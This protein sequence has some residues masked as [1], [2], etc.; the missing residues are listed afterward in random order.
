MESN[1]HLALN[2]STPAVLRDGTEG[3]RDYRANFISGAKG[4]G[5]RWDSRAIKAESLAVIAL[6][7][8]VRTG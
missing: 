4:I 1:D 2:G 6:R 8:L 3:S 5:E 7:M